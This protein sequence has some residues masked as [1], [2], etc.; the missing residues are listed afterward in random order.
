VQFRRRLTYANVV[1]TLALFLA[2]SGGLAW[3][4][5]KITSKQIGKGA[6]KTKNLAKNAVRAKNLAKNAVTTSKLQANAVTNAKLADGSVNLAKLAAGT[7]VVATATGGAVAANQKGPVPL[8]S[9]P[10]TLT[11]VAGQP[12]TV[13]A[14]AHSTLS[15][16]GCMV[17]ILPVVN[18]FPLAIG[19]LFVMGAPNEP[20]NPLFPQGLPQA[21]IT[22]PL[23]LREAGKPVSLNFEMIGDE[24]D[25]SPGST[26]DEIAVAVMQA[27]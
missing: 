27:K 6:V 17:A 9:S 10:L 21:G 15:G 24:A 16:D 12:L 5:H 25:C 8:L 2:L 23:G 3:A 22:F 18:G 11:P 26:L 7:N 20:P 1:S 19:E 14:E 4:A 13:N